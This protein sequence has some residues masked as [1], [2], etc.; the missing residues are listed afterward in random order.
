M[1]KETTTK[2]VRMPF[3]NWF[4]RTST[5]PP[6]GFS[7]SDRWGILH[8]AKSNAKQWI[9][10]RAWR[11]GWHWPMAYALL[12]EI[13]RIL[14]RIRFS[15][16]TLWVDQARE[17]CPGLACHLDRL[18]CQHPECIRT[19][20]RIHGIREEEKVIPWMGRFEG[21]LFFRGW[22]A[23]E[24]FLRCSSYI[25]KSRESECP[26]TR[27][28]TGIEEARGSSKCDLSVPPP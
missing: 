19:H 5:E 8:R 10:Q 15:L 9:Q 16:T 21:Y 26:S 17:L 24:R 20:A 12:L 14:P 11:F 6:E 3:W 1:S 7:A 25:G 27:L 22:N 4:I 18:E 23:A 13:Y 28:S 2:N